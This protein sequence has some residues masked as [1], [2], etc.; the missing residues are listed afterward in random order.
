MA[1]IKISELSSAA[2]LTGAEEIVLVQGGTTY[3]ATLDDV[4]ALSTLQTVTDNDNTTTNDIIIQGDATLGLY[5]TGAIQIT[6]NSAAAEIGISGGSVGV[7][8]LTTDSHIGT[9]SSEDLTDDRYYKLPDEAGTLA[10]ST[11]VGYSGSKTIGGQVY[12]WE[13]GILITVV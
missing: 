12:T 8:R 9:L 11:I 3:N 5:G 1:D 7:L 6:Q 4:S 13:N 10:V 2:P